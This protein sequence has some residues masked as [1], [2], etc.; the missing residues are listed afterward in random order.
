MKKRKINHKKYKFTY[1]MSTVFTL[2]FCTLFLKGY[3]PFERTGDNFFHVQVN[4]QA[5]GDVGDQ[6]DL[7]ELLIQARR[8]VASASSDLVFMEAQL[9]VSGEEV[10]W[11][12]IDDRETV[13]ANM[14]A[15]LRGSIRE[16]MHRSYTM[17]V[18]EYIVNLGSVEEVNQLLQA[19]VDKYDHENKF[20][21]E[22]VYDNNREFNVLTTNVV[23]STRETENSESTLHEGGIQSFIDNIGVPLDFEGEKDF[24][25]YDLGILEMDFSEEVEIVESYLP[26]SQLTLLSDAIDQVTKE[27]EVPSEYEVIA[28]DTLSEIAI[29][30]NIPM[31]DIVAMN[32]SLESIT[33]T[34]QI[35]QKLVIT[36]PEPEVSVT[37]MEE[38]YYEESYEADVIYIDND[39]WYTTK[40]VVHRQPSAG[41]RKVVV[42]V[43]YVNDKEVSREILKEEI[44]KE[45]V[46]KIVERGT[47]IPPTYIK[48]ISGGRKSSGFGRRNTGIKGAS[49]YHKGID[50]ATPTGTPV[51]ASCG[52]TV[53]R[54]GWGSGYGYVVYIDHEDGRQTRYGH[55]SK[56]LVKVGQTVKQ[57]ER[58]A[59][60]GNT[61]I[62]SGPHLHFEILING[63]QVNPEKYLQ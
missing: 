51:Y 1:I 32:D 28:G 58:I 63:V 55:L 35:G 20:R 19:A 18:N 5:V 30:V 23:D 42:D 25:D 37:R 27:Q 8:N 11:G 9:E 56:V 22:L 10:L 39:E 38:Q 24:E 12:E 15:A 57:G 26:V 61:G 60:S 31:D 16:T 14:E 50:W 43:C 48:P 6:E 54:A 46:A 34:L 29:K 40:T 49:T 21:V 44:V 53:S 47:K 52:G 7:E 2:F 13:L 45:A 4:G 41:F 59:L 36:V 17:K 33:T 62:T 3:T